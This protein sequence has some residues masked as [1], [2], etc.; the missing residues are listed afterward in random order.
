MLSS[1]VVT[2]QEGHVR[3]VLLDR[4]IEGQLDMLPAVEFGIGIDVLHGMTT[5]DLSYSSSA[6]LRCHLRP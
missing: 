1:P 3:A 6:V 5:D 2:F 4:L